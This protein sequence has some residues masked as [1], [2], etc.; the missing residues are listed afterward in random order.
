MAASTSRTGGWG[1]RGRG[2][3]RGGRGGS[4]TNS[5]DETTGLGDDEGGEDSTGVAPAWEDLDAEDTVTG[6]GG[7]RGGGRGG[8]GRSKPKPKWKR[9]PKSAY[10]RAAGE[11]YAADIAPGTRWVALNLQLKVL[12]ALCQFFVSST[13]PTK[14]LTC[15][16][17]PFL[18]AL[19]CPDVC[20]PNLFLIGRRVDLNRNWLLMA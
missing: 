8:R 12:I 11:L 1:G 5:R 17:R 3:G 20:C 6:G 14:L 18:Q 16:L 4:R 7:G 13:T 10:E 9:A 2:R 19:F 15:S